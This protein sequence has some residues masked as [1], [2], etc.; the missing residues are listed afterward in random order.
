[1]IAR[2]P[3]QRGFASIPESTLKFLAGVP[4][5]YTVWLER[6]GGPEDLRI[7]P[8]SQAPLTGTSV[9]TF[10]THGQG[11][12]R[13]SRLTS[14]IRSSIPT[15]HDLNAEVIC[16]S[17]NTGIVFR[18]YNLPADRYEQSRCDLL[19]VLPG[20][21]PDAPPDMFYV[22]PWLKLKG[23]DRFPNAADQSTPLVAGTGSMEPP[24]QPM[25]ARR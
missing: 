5:G 22:D 13:W 2:F 16:E 18:N 15:S 8:G 25:A 17:T 4:A 19:V 1:M 21:Y 12:A 14:R 10:F 3:Y 20:G 6:P 11:T 7:E 24:Q 23:L 9:E